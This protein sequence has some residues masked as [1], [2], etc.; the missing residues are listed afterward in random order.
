M[1]ELS[2]GKL[3]AQRTGEGRVLSAVGMPVLVP[4]NGQNAC[5]CTE[6]YHSAKYLSHWALRWIAESGPQVL[7]SI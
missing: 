5:M 1:S 7:G 4:P 2:M 6:A 3:K